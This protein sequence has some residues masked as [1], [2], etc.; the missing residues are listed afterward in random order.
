VGTSV[1]FFRDPDLQLREPQLWPKTSRIGAVSECP[2]PERP[3]RSNGEVYA[4]PSVRMW[5]I[6]LKKSLHG[7][8][9]PLATKS[10][11]QIGPQTARECRATVRRPPKTSREILSATFS[12]V[13]AARCLSRPTTGVPASADRARSTTGRFSARWTVLQIG[14]FALHQS[15]LNASICQAQCGHRM[16]AP[17]V[18]GDRLTPHAG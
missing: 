9:D 11:S 4:R 17:G 1:H 15:G 18:S 7:F 16:T 12:T 3:R 8:C 5:P 10:T 14:C 6:V 13:S 2:I